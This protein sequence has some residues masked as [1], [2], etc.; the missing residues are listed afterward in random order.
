M[1]KITLLKMP[2]STSKPSISKLLFKKKTL[3][4]LLLTQSNSVILYETAYTKPAGALFCPVI[5]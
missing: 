2:P 5:V 1:I 3:K 4:N